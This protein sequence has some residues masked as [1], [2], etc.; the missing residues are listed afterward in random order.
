MC[1]SIHVCARAWLKRL[2]SFSSLSFSAVP[3]H[4]WSGVSGSVLGWELVPWLLAGDWTTGMSTLGGRHQ[5]GAPRLWLDKH[6]ARLSRG[7]ALEKLREEFPDLERRRRSNLVR[8]AYGTKAASAS[9]PV[10]KC[11]TP[12]AASTLSSSSSSSSSSPSSSTSVSLETGWVVTQGQTG[13]RNAWHSVPV[14]EPVVPPPPVPAPVLPPPPAPAT[15][16]PAVEVEADTYTNDS[17]TA[18][19][20]KSCL[21]GVRPRSGGRWVLSWGS[22]T[23]TSFEKTPPELTND[24]FWAEEWKKGDKDGRPEPRWPEAEQWRQDGFAEGRK[25]GTW[26]LVL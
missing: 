21:K 15:V 12:S 2:L 22:P 6:K 26:R 8:A 9:G 19:V 4:P 10:Q 16:V 13:K 7:E 3:A 11:S 25:P 1:I 17:R 14:P 5:K 23:T 20:R 24:L 18:T